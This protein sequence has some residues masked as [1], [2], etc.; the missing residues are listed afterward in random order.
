M[1]DLERTIKSKENENEQLLKELED[2]NVS[3][4]ERKHIE[5]VNGKSC[6]VV[7]EDSVAKSVTVN[8]NKFEGGSI[9]GIHVW[10]VGWLVC[11]K[12]FVEE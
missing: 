3:V 2:L 7:L 8:W 11:S 12:M 1:K 10:L 5:Q 4:H 6:T 9:I